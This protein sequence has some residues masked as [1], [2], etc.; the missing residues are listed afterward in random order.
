MMHHIILWLAAM[1]INHFEGT[2][3]KEKF[4]TLKRAGNKMTVWY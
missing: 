2:L 1:S 4:Q 3:G